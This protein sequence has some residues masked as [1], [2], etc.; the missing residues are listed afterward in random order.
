MTRTDI[1]AEAVA[2]LESA[3][4]V[5][6]D[7]EPSIHRMQQLRAHARQRHAALADAIDAGRIAFEALHARGELAGEKISN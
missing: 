6:H 1:I 7:L 2:K 3:L 4:G 5:P